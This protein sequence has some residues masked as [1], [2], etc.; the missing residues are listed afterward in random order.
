MNKSFLAARLLNSYPFGYTCDDG[1]WMLNGKPA[2]R[3]VDDETHPY[4]PAPLRFYYDMPVRFRSE[5]W[6]LPNGKPVSSNAQPICRRWVQAALTGKAE[7]V[8]LS[9]LPGR[10]KS[11]TAWWMAMELVY[12]GAKV[13]CVGLNQLI[14]M[15]RLSYS[16]NSREEFAALM[17]ECETA[18]ILMLDDVGMGSG[19]DI[20]VLLLRI[21]DERWSNCLPTICTSNFTLHQLGDVGIDGRIASR[22]AGSLM[23]SIAGPDHRAN[24]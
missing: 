4:I 8:W 12:N 6:V 22:L 18:S 15:L 20:R 1:V 19:D 9:G 16:S 7:S 3:D 11:Q 21:I 17:T 13:K 5:P 14:V 23:V 2:L 24:A 10:G